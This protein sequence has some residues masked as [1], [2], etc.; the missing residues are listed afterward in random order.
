MYLKT[1]EHEE[2]CSFINGP[3]ASKLGERLSYLASTVEEYG[4][5]VEIGSLRGKSSCFMAAGVR[6]GGKMAK[7]HCVDLWTLGGPTQQ[8]NHDKQEIFESFKKNI[9]HFGFRDIIRQ[10]KIGSVEFAKKWGGEN[11]GIDFLF[12]DGGHT[13][14]ACL[15]DYEAWREFVKPGGWIAFHDYQDMHPGVMRV[16]DEVV[17]SEGLFENIHITKDVYYVPRK[18]M[19]V[20]QIMW[21]AQRKV[22]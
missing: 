10:H 18:K 4:S 19:D 6:F 13:Y 3:M 8:K 2:I 16:I 20:E 17:S 22:K 11:D 1:P 9:E 5:I 15:A 14:E 21:S 7:I 12:I